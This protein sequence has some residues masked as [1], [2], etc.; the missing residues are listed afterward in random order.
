MRFRNDWFNVHL[1]RSALSSCFPKTNCGHSLCV[2]LFTFAHTN[3][4]HPFSTQHSTH[5]PHKY[6]TTH[7]FIAMCSPTN[8]IRLGRCYIFFKNYIRALY[9]K[10]KRIYC[11]PKLRAPKTTSTV[12]TEHNFVHV[13]FAVRRQP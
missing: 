7:H 11:N 4:S 10:P 12:C 3:T 5:N 9:R 8:D 6:K 13:L 1:H 2:T